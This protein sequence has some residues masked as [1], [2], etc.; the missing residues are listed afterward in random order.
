MKTNSMVM[1]VA[2]ACLML[3]AGATMPFTAMAG[4]V[5]GKI[6]FKGSAPKAKRIKMGQDDY[7]VKYYQGKTA[8]RSESTSVGGDGS[9]RWVFVYVQAGLDKKLKG[10]GVGR[11]TTLDQRG[12][13]YGPRVFGMLAGQELVINNSDET[14]HNFHLLGKNKY[15]R[16]AGP[17]KSI[18]RKVKKAAKLKLKK[19]KSKVM[20]KIKCDIHPWMVA[21]VGVLPHSFYSVT[22]K[23]GEFEIKDLPAGDY[24][25]AAWHEK[26]GTQTMKISVPASGA[27][28][29]NFEFSK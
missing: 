1:A 18:T 22:G 7:C 28:T 23:T 20:S 14:K 26:L 5:K 27:K 9:L 6:S 10:G 12:C 15:N 16:S 13:M 25:L 4:T 8:P 2:G 11:K 29:V 17:G 24:T 21:Y 3:W 19:G